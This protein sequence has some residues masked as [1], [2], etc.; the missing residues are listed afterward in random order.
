M[1]KLKVEDY[2]NN[3]PDEQRITLTK[4]RSL[5]KSIVPDA[6]EVISYGMPTFKY[7][8]M[9]VSYAAFKNHLSFFPCNGHLIDEFKED[10]QEFTTSKGT[11]QFTSKHTIPVAVIRKIVRTRIRENLSKVNS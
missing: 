5:I 10:L 4:L 2:I 1:S 6:E 8:G 3:L 9:L 11:I 7:H